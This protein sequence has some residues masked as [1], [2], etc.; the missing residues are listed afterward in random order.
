MTEAQKLDVRR[1]LDAWLAGAPWRSELTRL[2]GGLWFVRLHWG[3][4]KTGSVTCV[5]REGREEAA[6]DALAA[7]ALAETAPA[8]AV[9][10]VRVVRQEVAC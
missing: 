9:R 3:D 8:S 2:K 10:L 7:A 6:A 5:S 4:G 1:R